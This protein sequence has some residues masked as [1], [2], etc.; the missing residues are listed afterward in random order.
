MTVYIA[1]D[2]LD[3]PK[4]LGHELEEVGALQFRPRR[5][6]LFAASDIADEALAEKT[7]MGMAWFRDNAHVA[8]AL[9]ERGRDDNIEQAR[10]VGRAFLQ[11]LQANEQLL[12]SATHDPDAPRLPV[13]VQADTLNNDS[14]QRFQNDS[15][16]YAIW[17]PA[18]L[19]LRGLLEP[20]RDDLGMFA[21]TARYLEAGRFWQQ[22]D[23]GQWEED[24]QIHASSI[25]VVV[26]SLSAVARV[27]DRHDYKTD[28]DLQQVINRGSDVL[29]TILGQYG[30]TPPTGDYPG[31]QYDASHLFLT[32]SL[33]LFDGASK[34]ANRE[35]RQIEE[36]LVR[37][38]GTIRYPGDSYY[39]PGFTEM[40]APGERTSQA[41]GRLEWRNTL[42]PDAERAQT[43]A[44]WTLFDPLLSSYWGRQ[45]AAT[46]D[47]AHRQRQLY[48]LN[49]SLAQYVEVGGQGLHVPELY[50]KNRETSPWTTN[51][52][53]PLIWSQANMLLALEQFE[54]SV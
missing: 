14:E 15:T 45:Y 32:E 25:G 27:F 40:L 6:G 13:R 47:V 36:R 31:R 22:A 2:F 52:H 30:E 39:A 5:S 29:S 54:K 41:E 9:S 10:G 3:S 4:R 12:Y 43:E 24:R 8:N 44:Q 23:E 33:R 46:K 21:A 26:A 50:Y 7:G 35:V 18:Q 38:K 20:S 19:M 16:G 34:L 53:V 48:Y 1:E 37:S 11:I 42:G 17:L 49:R 28:V 51:D